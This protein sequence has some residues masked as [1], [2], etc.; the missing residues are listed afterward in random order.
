M[1]ASVP[2]K[3]V[4]TN[5]NKIP[6]KD[7]HLAH[8]FSSLTDT[9]FTNCHS[10]Y[11]IDNLQLRG[12]DSWML[13][14][15][16]TIAIM[17]KVTYQEGTGDK[18]VFYPN[19]VGP[20]VESLKEVFNLRLNKYSTPLIIGGFAFIAIA[21]LLWIIPWIRERRRIPDPPIG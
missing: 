1:L 2:F 3:L 16:S 14:F 10:I 8:G 7:I 17:G 12:T 15:G 4:D 13:N 19:K 18:L 6:V 21:A 5:K 9:V 20:T 11:G